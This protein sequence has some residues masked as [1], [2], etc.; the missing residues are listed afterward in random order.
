MNIETIYAKRIFFSKKDQWNKV[1][2]LIHKWCH[3][4]N[5]DPYII[6]S[7]YYLEEYFRPPWFQA[8]EHLMFKTH[9]ISNPS[10]GP[11]QV[12]H[13]NLKQNNATLIEAS[14]V[15]VNKITKKSN[16]SSNTIKRNFISF[17]KLYNLDEMYGKVMYE[18]YQLIRHKKWKLQD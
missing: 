8:I 11:F 16:L 6:L 1:T 12:R 3:G 5:T 7:V 14:I 13:E 10:L 4:K 18:L 2:N 17:G 9:I 15:Y